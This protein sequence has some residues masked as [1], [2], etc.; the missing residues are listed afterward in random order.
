MTRKHFELIARVLDAAMYL[1]PD[2]HKQLA[3][4][5]AVE[6]ADTNSMFDRERFIKACGVE[7]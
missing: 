5:F 6:L 4:E 7:S 3:H 2:D 1:G